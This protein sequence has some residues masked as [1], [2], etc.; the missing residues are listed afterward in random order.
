MFGTQLLDH[1]LKLTRCDIT[2]L[3]FSFRLVHRPLLI[4]KFFF[5]VLADFVETLSSLFVGDDVSPGYAWDRGNIAV[6][7]QAIAGLRTLALGG[8]G[9]GGGVEETCLLGAPLRFAARARRSQAG[10]A[11]NRTWLP[12]HE[13]CPR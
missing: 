5:S 3:H 2:K 9:V 11:F 7:L 4:A 6:G 10:A 13:C 1:V 12:L 8:A